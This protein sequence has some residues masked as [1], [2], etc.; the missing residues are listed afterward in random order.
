MMDRQERPKSRSPYANSAELSPDEK[1]L[2]ES[3]L[4][5]ENDEGADPGTLSEEDIRQPVGAM[6]RSEVTGK[7]DAGSQ[8]NETDDGL[9]SETEAVR[10]A[11]EDTPT[12]ANEKKKGIPVFDRAGAPPK[13]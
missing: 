2:V 11:A 8:A 4:G 5:R 12:G 3:G 9:D 10:H 6:R 1:N 13:I 7:H